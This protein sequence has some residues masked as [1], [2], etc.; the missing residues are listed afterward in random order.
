[1]TFFNPKK[2]IAA[3]FEVGQPKDKTVSVRYNN[4]KA[5]DNLKDRI[6]VEMEK[7]R[8][9]FFSRNLITKTRTPDS[10]STSTTVRPSGL[11]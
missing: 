9:S 6:V 11:G 3:A 5:D 10:A 2:K 4:E 1:M 8:P 7:E